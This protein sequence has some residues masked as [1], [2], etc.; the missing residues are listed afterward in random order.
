M[1]AVVTFAFGMTMFMPLPRLGRERYRTQ[2]KWAGLPLAT[3]HAA[4]GQFQQKDAHEVGGAH[5]RAAKHGG[6]AI[7][8]FHGAF[9]SKTY[10]LS[11]K[12]DCR[13]FW[14]RRNKQHIISGI[15]D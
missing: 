11:C 13:T 15:E 12:S 4:H 9:P 6:R 10:S 14:R 3:A 8:A 5:A 1:S 7:L 2:Q